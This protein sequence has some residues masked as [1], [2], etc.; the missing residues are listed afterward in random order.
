MHPHS[1][2]LISTYL[3]LFQE[4]SKRCSSA[5]LPE[6]ELRS[7]G[8]VPVKTDRVLDISLLVSLPDLNVAFTEEKQLSPDLFYNQI[9]DLQP[10][11][12]GSV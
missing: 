11:L 2:P 7:L 8:L 5:R 1:D 6:A 9:L 3:F 12:S 4:R 10:G